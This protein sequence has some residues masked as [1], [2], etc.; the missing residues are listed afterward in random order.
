MFHCQEVPEAHGTAQVVF[1]YQPHHHEEPTS[2]EELYQPHHHQPK[3]IKLA[4]EELAQ[5]CQVGVFHNHPD[6]TIIL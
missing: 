2:A 4:I 1:M 6:H 3:A 5:F